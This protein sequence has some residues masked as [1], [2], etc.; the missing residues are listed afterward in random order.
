MDIFGGGIILLTTG[1]KEQLILRGKKAQRGRG[2]N[3]LIR[4]MGSRCK[5]LRF[6]IN[7]HFFLKTALP[8]T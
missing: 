7:S 4:A 6:E 2:T 5:F 3:A 1:S 8:A